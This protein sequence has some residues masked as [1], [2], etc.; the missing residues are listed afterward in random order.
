MAMVPAEIIML[1]A[2]TPKLFALPPLQVTRI[3]QMVVNT[4]IICVGTKALDVDFKGIIRLQD[5]RALEVDKVVMYDC[6]RPGDVVQAEVVSLGDARSYY[7]STAK[8]E[9]GVVHARSLAGVPMVA[10]SWE[11][12]QCPDTLVVEKRKVAKFAASGNPP[13]MMQA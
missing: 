5:V 1:T 10:V 4:K 11:A 6:F 3:S 12:M 2:T 8:N 7:L 9:L 13:V